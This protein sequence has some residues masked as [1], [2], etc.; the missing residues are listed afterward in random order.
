MHKIAV[1]ATFAKIIDKKG[2]KKHGERAVAD[3]YKY[4]THI[5]YMKVVGALDPTRLTKSQKRGHYMQ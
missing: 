1:D 2:I 5:E 3:M 4:Y